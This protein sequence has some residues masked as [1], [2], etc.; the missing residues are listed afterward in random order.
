MPGASFHSFYWQ[1]QAPEP[2]ITAGAS[3]N[4]G[5]PTWQMVVIGSLLLMICL[6]GN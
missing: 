5:Y 4:G 3:G 6:Q 2:P 1:T